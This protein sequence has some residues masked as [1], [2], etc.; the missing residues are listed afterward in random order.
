[1]TI[2]QAWN[3][4]WDVNVTGSQVMTHTFM[5]LLVKSKDPRLMFLASGTA[6]LQE[7]FNEAIHYNKSPP[8]GWPKAG[9]AT[10]STASYRSTKVGL[11]MMMRE[12]VKA[13]KED[14]VK[15]FA[16]SPGFLATNL[17]G[18]AELYAKFGAGDPANGGR[19]IKDVVDGKRDDDAGKVIRVDK[20][21]PW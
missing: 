6:S 10:I 12:W 20:V 8:A 17:G 3:K 21:Q 13:L 14:G 1:M 18:N 7:S 16:I 2:R 19:F 9:A 4:S 11:N 5:P 15:V